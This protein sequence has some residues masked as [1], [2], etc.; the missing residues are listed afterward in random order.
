VEH[1]GLEFLSIVL[2]ICNDLKEDETLG[3][4]SED[5]LANNSRVTVVD[6]N[7]ETEEERIKAAADNLLQICDTLKKLGRHFE[8]V[9]EPQSSQG[10]GALLTRPGHLDD[11]RLLY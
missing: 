1:S 2:C 11:V 4:H 3:P 8:I 10:P 7:D 5:S 9:G 6:A